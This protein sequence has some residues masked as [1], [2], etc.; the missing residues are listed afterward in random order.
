MIWLKIFF[1]F[2]GIRSPAS[3]ENKLQVCKITCYVEYCSSSIPSKATLAFYDLAT[4]A[5]KQQYLEV[6]FPQVV[7][8]SLIKKS[9]S[10]S[11]PSC[12]LPT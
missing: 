3:D 6:V 1:D 8:S 5:A 4:K 7:Y 2:V 9:P 10:P 12:L 11:I